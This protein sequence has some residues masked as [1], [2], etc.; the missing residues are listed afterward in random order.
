M[1]RS[2][3]V[4][5]TM[6][7][8]P[9]EAQARAASALVEPARAVGLR[10]TKRGTGELGYR[11]RVQFPFVIMLWHALNGERMTVTFRPEER[12]GTRVAIRGAVAGSR[13]PLATVRRTLVGAARRSTRRL[14]ARGARP[15]P[16]P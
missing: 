11:P 1:A 13:L 14:T 16:H 2:F 8:A 9:V 5:L 4:E 7:E 10:L 3:N 15:A 6:R 12:G